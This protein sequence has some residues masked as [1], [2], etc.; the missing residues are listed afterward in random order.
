MNENDK[1]SIIFIYVCIYVHYII[2]HYPCF[3]YL[4]TQNTYFMN[5]YIKMNGEW[6]N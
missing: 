5:K 3:L 4:D 2:I 6:E 1:T